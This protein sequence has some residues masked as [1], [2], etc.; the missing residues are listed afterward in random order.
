ML[1]TRLTEAEL[2]DRAQLYTA[3]VAQQ[4]ATTLLRD[5]TRRLRQHVDDND[6]AGAQMALRQG[7]EGLQQ[8]R[9][10]VPPEPYVLPD[11]IADL[12]RTSQGLI[13]GWQSLDRLIHIPSG[14]ITLFA[15]RP[16]HGKTTVLLNLLVNLLERYPDRAFYLYSYEEARAILALKIIMLLAGKVLHHEFNQEAYLGYLKGLRGTDA[17]IE[18]AKERFEEYTQSGRLWLQDRRLAAE[19]LAASIASL[20]GQAGAVLVDYIQKVP[21]TR[22]A[23]QRYLEVKEAS[24]L[25]LEQAVQTN[26]PIIVGAQLGRAQGTGQKVRLDNLREAGDL[27]QD[28][29]LVVGIYNTSVERVE[30]EGREDP[31]PVVDLELSILKQRGGVA[32]RKATL[33][34]ERPTL[35]LRDRMTSGLY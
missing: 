14:A 22:P 25:L 29:A 6:L 23:S 4:Q 8:S 28:A 33:A 1:A 35:R 5:L 9:G 17:A 26:I 32:G 30:D 18:R 13:T 19:D 27:E 7:L 21:L 2:Q 24:A 16:G 15:G 10:A 3:Q 31:E 11:V 34:F 12:Q 20:R